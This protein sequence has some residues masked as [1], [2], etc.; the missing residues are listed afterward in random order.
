MNIRELMNRLDRIELSEAAAALVNPWTGTDPESQAKARAWNLL[1]A[2]DQEWIGGADPTDKY[3]L[4]R[5]PNKGMYK[6]EKPPLGPIDSAVNAIRNLPGYLPA[7]GTSP[8]TVQRD[9]KFYK[10]DSAGNTMLDTPYV[11]RNLTQPVKI[12]DKSTV[13][14]SVAP[15]GTA[16]QSN[17]PPTSTTPPLAPANK[18]TTATN[19][20]AY[21]PEYLAHFNALLDKV[22]PQG[23]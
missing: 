19:N 18:P 6:N 5:A 13:A 16:P 4:A 14:A 3:I 17:L 12:I 15:S 21:D 7:T 23:K 9:G 2:K 10:I 11:D 8:E 1:S 20:S 22:A